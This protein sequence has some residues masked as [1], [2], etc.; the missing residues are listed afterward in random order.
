MN[1]FS[2]FLLT[3]LLAAGIMAGVLAAAAGAEASGRRPL[4][5][6]LPTVNNSYVKGGP[7]LAATTNDRLR[8]KYDM[9]RYI[10]LHGQ[11]LADSV[12]RYGVYDIAALDEA[13]CREILRG[14][15][16]DYSVRAELMPVNAR[17]RIEFP[18]V[19]MF[20]KSWQAT[21]PL[22]I[23]VTNVAAGYVIFDG[24]FA[25]QGVHENLIGF[26]SKENAIWLSLYKALDRMDAEAPLP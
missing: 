10:L 26:A 3:V 14:M 17:Q 11:F 12:A 5:A 18:T 2:G 7:S 16:V 19:L 23:T 24:V 21:I 4:L 20:V 22:R 1:R 13:S 8:S 6:L 15:G 25:E 9:D